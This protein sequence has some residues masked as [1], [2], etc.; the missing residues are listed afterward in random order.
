[1]TS[2]RKISATPTYAILAH[3]KE[4]KTTFQEINKISPT[5]E[6]SIEGLDELATGTITEWHEKRNFFAVKWKKK[7]EKFDAKTE[8]QSGLRVFFKLQLFSTQVVFKSAT[9]RRIDENISHFRIPEQL[10][11]QQRRGALRVPV[12]GMHAYV[13]T[14]KGEFPLVNLSVAGARASHGTK[15]ISPQLLNVIL[16]PCTIVLGRR[17]ISNP[18]LGVRITHVDETGVGLL[19]HG[20]TA[21]DKIFIK[22]YLVEALRTYFESQQS[23]QVR[24]EK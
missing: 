4:L 6:V 13:I 8:S 22:Q 15:K 23:T 19:F 17:R 18:S 20:L 16:D 7:S 9:L 14:P 21:H 12:S 1:M 10:Y 11:K 2:V 5:A 3:P 24:K